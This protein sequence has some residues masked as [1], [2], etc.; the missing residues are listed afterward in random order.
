MYN[1]LLLEAHLNIT[2][3]KFCKVKS[4]HVFRYKNKWFLRSNVVSN[5]AYITDHLGRRKDN[6]A[7]IFE[8]N[9]IVAQRISKFS[10]KD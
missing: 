9:Q 10:L 2:F 7:H 5:I 1:P 6:F 3:K 4:G 8:V